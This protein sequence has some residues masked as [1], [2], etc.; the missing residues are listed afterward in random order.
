MYHDA[1]HL[2]LKS[3]LAA[4]PL[5]AILEVSGSGDRVP[6]HEPAGIRG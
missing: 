2:Y 6:E 5:A 1:A 4:R 3:C